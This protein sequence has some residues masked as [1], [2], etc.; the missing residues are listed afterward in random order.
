M[1]EAEI[2][3]LGRALERTRLERV[4]GA[5]A[6]AVR[7]Q[8]PG[9]VEEDLAGVHG[10]GLT[11]IVEA[12]LEA[13]RPLSEASCAGLIDRLAGH[14]AGAANVLLEPSTETLGRLVTA[15]AAAHPEARGSYLR[16]LA[17]ARFSV[18]DAAGA[19]DAAQQALDA[20]GLTQRPD[21]RGLRV[22]LLRLL[23][24]SAVELGKPARARAAFEAILLIEPGDVESERWL[25]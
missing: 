9:P 2:L 16:A 24:R 6:A 13:Q 4:S 11:R 14:L 8:R 20:R 17:A 21:Q 15:C 5:Y 23:G 19:F 7:S 3:S 1:S 12:S 10:G 18:G 22:D 25:R